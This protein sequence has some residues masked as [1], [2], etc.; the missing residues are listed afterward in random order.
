MRASVGRAERVPRLVALDG[1]GNEADGC[2]PPCWGPAA[3]AAA[4]RVVLAVVCTWS[5]GASCRVGVPRRLGGVGYDAIDCSWA[6]WLV[7]AWLALARA[8]W[9]RGYASS[10]YVAAGQPTKI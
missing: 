7:V 9:C 10:Y 5:A 4:A 6:R 3:A 2:W 8:T 1:I